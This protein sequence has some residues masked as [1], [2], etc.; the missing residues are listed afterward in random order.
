MSPSECGGEEEKAV[1][2][3]KLKNLH[4]C[5][6]LTSLGTAA[7]GAVALSW[8]ARN[9]WPA[10]PSIGRATG[11]WETRHRK[12]LTTD[13]K[14]I[15]VLVETSIYN[16]GPSGHM[17]MPVMVLAYNNS[18]RLLSH[19]VVHPTTPCVNQPTLRIKVTELCQCVPSCLLGLTLR[20][21][22]WLMA[23]LSFSVHSATTL[24]RISF[25]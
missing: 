5:L 12:I 3:C 8:P 7:C 10:P 14:K 23:A 20:P 21:R 24:A 4:S 13:R 15:G 17:K 19:Q 1:T 22:I 25:M 6:V 2:T 9:T 11:K 18:A 16:I